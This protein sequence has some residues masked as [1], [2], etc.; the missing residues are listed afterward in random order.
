[1][2]TA[3]IIPAYN[4]SKNLAKVIEETKQYVDEVIVSNDG[5]SDN[6]ERIA[7]KLADYTLSHCI[8]LGVG[9]ALKTGYLFIKKKR[10][11]VDKIITGISQSSVDAIPPAAA[12]QPACRP[13]ISTTMTRRWLWVVVLSISRNSQTRFIAVSNP[14]V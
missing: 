6:T 3:A 13:M 7:D 1:M 11:N 9:A 4:E 14:N 10:R 8:N 2:T 5:S 12:I